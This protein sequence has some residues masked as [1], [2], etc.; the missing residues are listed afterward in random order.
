MDHLI[1]ESDQVGQEGPGFHEPRQQPEK[2]LFLTLVL[3]GTHKNQDSIFE[4]SR[5]YHNS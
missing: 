4:T 1:I 2:K 3:Y 5:C